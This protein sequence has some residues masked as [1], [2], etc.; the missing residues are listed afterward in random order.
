MAVYS[1]SVYPSSTT[2]KVD[3]WYYGAYAIVDASSYCSTDVEWYSS[4]TSV[5]T[6]NE[7][8]GYIYARAAGTAR[9][10]ARSTV[11]SSKKDYITVTVT[12]GTIYVESITLNESVR[13]LEKGGSFEL[14]A[15]VCPTNATNKTISW[16]STNT[17]VATVSGG[18]V[19]AKSSGNAYIYAEAQDGSGKYARCYV[20]VTENVLVN[21][22]TLNYSEYTLNP[23]ESVM[24]RETVCPTDATND[25][26]TWCSSDESVAMVNPDSGLVLAIGSGAAIIRATAIDGSGVYA[27]CTIR[28]NDPIPVTDISI[29]PTSLTMSVG[30]E[31]YLCV[32]IT[33][34]N[35]TNKSVVWCSSDESVAEV[36]FRTGK[37]TAKCFGEP[38]SQQP[39]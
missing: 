27:E 37:I 34:S 19:T 23:N 14:S 13:Y 9:I 29:C 17:S 4:N 35:A 39:C 6:V 7:S 15:T 12:S 32:E 18:E 25:C 24:L 3:S 30:D 31:R 21:S 33:P 10:Y 26:V 20:A 8:N 1:V 28:V 11:D 38:Q 2:I 22:I 5:A 36:D 16:R